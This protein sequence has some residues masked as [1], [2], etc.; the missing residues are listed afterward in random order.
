MTGGRASVE[1]INKVL[2]LLDVIARNSPSPFQAL[3]TLSMR[4]IIPLLIIFYFISNCDG[5]HYFILFYFAIYFIFNVFYVRRSHVK[6]TKEAQGQV[7]K[8]LEMSKDSFERK[9]LRWNIP[10]VFPTYIEL[11]R[12]YRSQFIES[13]ISQNLATNQ[14]DNFEVVTN[15]AN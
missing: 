6:R 10:T 11:L 9:G 12:E 15:E 3:F 8:I 2:D 7:Q 14:A 13:Q 5:R 1:E 4:F